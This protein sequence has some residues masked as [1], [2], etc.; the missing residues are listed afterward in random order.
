MKERE[1][2]VDQDLDAGWDDIKADVT[3]VSVKT[4]VEDESVADLDAGWDFD[5]PSSQSE[6]SKQ[7]NKSNAKRLPLQSVKRPAPVIPEAPSVPALTKK[8]RRELDRQNQI[9]AAKRKSE[10]KALRKQ[11]RLDI[12]H[13]P[14]EPSPLS[15]AEPTRSTA[16]ATPKRT[17][18][19][20]PKRQRPS[21]PKSEPQL[22]TRAS[23]EHNGIAREPNRKRESN[24]DDIAPNSRHAHPIEAQAVPAGKWRWWALGIALIIVLW[25]A[26][27]WILSGSK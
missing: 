4:K 5:E 17:K 12:K 18:K 25:V 22:S 19:S 8:A 1:S 3:S 23:S 10:A 21:Q 7:K 24:P 15:K 20:T 27:R 9:H 11:Q 6:A 14:A 16:A 26:A 2:D 13:Q